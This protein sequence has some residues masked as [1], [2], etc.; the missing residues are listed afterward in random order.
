MNIEQIKL[1]SERY[2][3]LYLQGQTEKYALM[4]KKNNNKF[5]TPPPPPPTEGRGQGGDNEETVNGKT[6]DGL[7]ETVI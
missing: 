5:Q 1:V 3:Q 6:F 2:Y 7:G 4:E